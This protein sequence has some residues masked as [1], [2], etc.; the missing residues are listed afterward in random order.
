LFVR[1]PDVPVWIKTLIF[2]V[3]DEFP[4]IVI[5]VTP[6]LLSVTPAKKRKAPVA[7]ADGINDIIFDVKS[8]PFANRTN[9]I[10]DDSVSLISSTTIFVLLLLVSLISKGEYFA[11]AQV[12]VTLMLLALRG[13]MIFF[14]VNNVVSL[15]IPLILPALPP[16]S[17]QTN[18]AI[19]IVSF[20]PT[21]LQLYTTVNG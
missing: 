3:F 4:G 13:T 16:C 21:I 12:L 20:N 19:R 17:P 5:E 1:A 7:L 9:D 18:G 14:P 6:E 11:D 10:P 2:R 15:L 8:V